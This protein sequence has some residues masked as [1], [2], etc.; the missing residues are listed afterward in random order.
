MENGIFWGKIYKGSFNFD[1]IYDVKL[2]ILYIFRENLQWYWEFEPNISSKIAFF[3]GENLVWNLEFDPNIHGINSW[4]IYFWSP[5]CEDFV[6]VKVLN[7]NE[8][9]ILLEIIYINNISTNQ[10]RLS[11]SREGAVVED[12]ARVGFGLRDCFFGS[13]VQ[14]MKRVL[15]W[16]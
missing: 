9:R 2:L 16:G 5:K 12:R 1:E 15:G 11:F 14:P 4:F 7:G 10:K 3:L 13:S 6:V 8:I